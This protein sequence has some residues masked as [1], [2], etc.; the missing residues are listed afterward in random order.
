MVPSYV[1]PSD[2]NGINA[3]IFR[4]SPTPHPHSCE[5]GVCSGATHC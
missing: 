1:I 2:R 5:L 3:K 4:K